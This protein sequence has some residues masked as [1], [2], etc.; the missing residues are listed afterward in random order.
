MAELTQS[1]I[2]NWISNEATGKFHYT[3]VMD[4][5][6]GRELYPQLRAVLHRL[7]DK[8]VCYPVDGRDG[9]WRPAD[10]AA[11][12][13]H[14]WD[15]EDDTDDNINLP[16]GMNKL[17]Y[18]PKPA[19]IIYAGKYNAG[20]TALCLNTINL[21]T[22]KWGDNMTLYVSEGEA[23]MAKKLRALK[24][25]VP[26]TFQ[27]Y[28]K[29]E[30]FADVIEPNGLSIIDYLRVDMS[31]PYEVSVKIFEIFNKL[32]KGIAVIAMQKPPGDRKLAFGGASTAFEPAL[33]LSMD[34]ITKTRSYI[35]FEKFKVI[36]PLDFDPYMLKIEFDIEQGIH[37][38][39]I[40]EIIE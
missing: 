38:N 7:K 15:M 24:I 40:S 23:M 21:N 26:P 30:N 2:E 5:L 12:E 39:N 8:K 28:R 20:K 25:P 17:C 32:D 1:Q 10:V 4:G 14:W 36:K 34:I 16:L 35:A 22:E 31:K 6:I 11:E 3:K 27:T 37:L 19:V 33:Y 9:W 29:T 13:L 18:I